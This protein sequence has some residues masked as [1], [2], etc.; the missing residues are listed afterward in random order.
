MIDPNTPK[1]MKPR[2]NSDG[3]LPAIAQD[4]STGEVLMMAWMNAEALT[5]TLREQRA[6]Y[7][8]RSRQR[9]WRKGESSGHVQRLAAIHLDCHGDTVL[10]KVHQEGGTACHTGRRS[11]FFY[12]PSTDGWQISE[13]AP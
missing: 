9:L 13:N 5:L 3:L 2:W 7:W 1:T 6:V 11:C 8:S 10:L 4:A 12:A